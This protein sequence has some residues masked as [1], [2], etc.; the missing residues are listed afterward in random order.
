MRYQ[1]GTDINGKYDIGQI[2]PGTY[3][4]TISFTGYTGKQ[5]TREIKSGVMTFQD[6]E[7]VPGVALRVV[8]VRPPLL[9]I[10]ETTDADRLTA[11]DFQHG[12]LKT[13]G[14]AVATAENVHARDNGAIHISGS[15][16]DANLVILDGVRMTGSI[17][18]PTNAISEFNV[19]SH[20][21]PA[22]YGDFTGGVIEIY[23]K[24]YFNH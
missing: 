18:I 19:I 12:G 11:E 23:T 1:A 13:I 4:V 20:G 24:S 9:D 21:F 7:L 5:F 2:T 14:D 17:H 10:G 6:M 15:R 3:Q 16:D 8:H 22:K